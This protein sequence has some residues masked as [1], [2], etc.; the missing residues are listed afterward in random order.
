MSNNFIKHEVFSVTFSV[1]VFGF[2]VVL[3][4]ICEV[5]FFSNT[6]NTGF[7]ELNYHYF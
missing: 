1:E 7:Q 4:E 6:K 5:E 3:I 2:Q